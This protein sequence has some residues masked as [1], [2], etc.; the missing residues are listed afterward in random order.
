MCVR[1]RQNEIQALDRSLRAAERPYEGMLVRT[2]P[3]LRLD[4]GRLWERF[5]MLIGMGCRR[6]GKRFDSR[7]S[8]YTQV[9]LHA[10]DRK[11]INEAG[12][13]EAAHTVRRRTT[14]RQTERS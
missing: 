8:R 12:A 9:L 13:R 10:D 4:G 7:G 11:G 14:G 6:G 5:R 2:V 1:G 3:S